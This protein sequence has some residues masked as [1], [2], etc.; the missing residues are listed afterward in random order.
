LIRGFL[1]FLLV[2]L[3]LSASPASAQG[4]DPTPNPSP[5]DAG[6]TIEGTI[7]NHNQEGLVPEG[8]SVMLHAWDQS[9]ADRG[10]IHGESGPNGLFTLENVVVEPGIFYAAM[11][12]YQNATY[13]SVPHLAEGDNPLEPFEVE[14]YESTN[15]LSGVKIDLLQMVF[16]FSQ[17]GLAV[18]EIYGLSNLGDRTV[19]N[20]VT[21]NDTSEATIMFSLPEDAAS[22]SF[23][24]SSDGRFV[25][26]LGGFADLQ[27]LV[28]GEGTGRI[29]VSYILPYE[30][31]IT[32][33]REVPLQAES[34]NLFIPHQSGLS[35]D[36]SDVEYIGVKSS[37]D[38]ESYE[39]YSLGSV[40]AEEKFS[41]TLTGAFEVVDVQPI[42]PLTDGPTINQEILV[43][44]GLL[45]IG[46]IFVGIWWWRREDVEGEL[47][48]FDPLPDPESER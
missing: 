35:L 23:P 48:D 21:I 20:A 40:V 16:G 27:P 19:A 15:D 42:A 12:V 11:V 45:G 10:M 29:F 25:S 31:G 18:G 24:G 30:D 34:V 2:L 4:E 39:H 5:V 3:L 6:I 47:E 13:L 37:S 41:I 44:A 1:A 46:M 8:L 28:P 32:F 38:G 26:Y 17:G 33:T 7:V 43:G 22:V 14:I 9:G 36:P